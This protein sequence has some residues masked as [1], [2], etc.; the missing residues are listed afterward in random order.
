MAEVA[1]RVGAVVQ[2]DGIV[3]FQRGKP[4]AALGNGGL[5]L[6]LPPNDGK[7]PVG[8]NPVG[9]QLDRTLRLGD[10]PFV[11]PERR[12]TIR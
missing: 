4:L 3:E 5:A 6:G 7:A 1:H 9:P 2:L 10:R 11:V 12:V 8:R